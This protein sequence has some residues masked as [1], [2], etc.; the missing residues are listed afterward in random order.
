MRLLATPYFPLCLAALCFAAPLFAETGSDNPPSRL[1]TDAP[2]TLE[3]AAL[4]NA[5]PETSDAQTP[6]PARADEPPAAFPSASAFADW[7]RKTAFRQPPA[8][9][10]PGLVQALPWLNAD[11]FVNLMGRERKEAEMGLF[12]AITL[13]RSMTRHPDLIPLMESALKT[14]RDESRPEAQALEWLILAARKTEAPTVS[15]AELP[16][17]QWKLAL[18]LWW[19]EYLATRARAPLERLI[20]ALAFFPPASQNRAQ[21]DAA[22]SAL[23]ILSFAARHDKNTLALC[24]EWREKTENEAIADALRL[25]IDAARRAAKKKRPAAGQ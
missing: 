3:S 17:E 5:S 24:K 19:A 8:V 11:T 2:D 14:A 25:V 22:L 7:W 18:N 9:S 16:Q 20:G 12:A 15:L 23:D 13:L 1:E 4:E 21:I 10:A 6:A